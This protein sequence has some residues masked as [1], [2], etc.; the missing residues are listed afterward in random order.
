M[1]LIDAPA[2]QRVKQSLDRNV[3]GQVTD[4]A[5][6]PGQWALFSVSKKWES[7]HRI[8]VLVT[9]RTTFR[10]YGDVWGRIVVQ[11]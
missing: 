9:E 7:E 2:Q 10:H 3:P 1:S 8:L 11:E 6:N 5:S 4:S